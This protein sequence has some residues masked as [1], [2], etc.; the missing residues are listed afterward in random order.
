MLT[1]FC[2]CSDKLEKM[3]NQFEEQVGIDEVT[4]KNVVII[5]LFYTDDGM[6]LENTFW[7]MLK[8]L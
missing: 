5:L 6:P 8:S 3:D 1:V 2:L 7:K 4:I